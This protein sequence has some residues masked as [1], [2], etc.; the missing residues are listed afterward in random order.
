MDSNLKKED[1]KKTYCFVVKSRDGNEYDI[2]VFMTFEAL[3]KYFKT[4]MEWQFSK[5]ITEEQF[6]KKCKD[7][8]II[9][10]KMEIIG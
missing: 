1:K 8:Y 4:E 2:G 6:I 5:S 7:A 9:V 10:D 3:L